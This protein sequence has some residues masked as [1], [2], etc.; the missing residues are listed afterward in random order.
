MGSCGKITMEWGGA[1]FS[2]EPSNNGQWPGVGHGHW[3]TV[4]VTNLCIFIL[5]QKLLCRIAKEHERF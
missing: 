4:R 1:E 5:C 3:Q 2:L